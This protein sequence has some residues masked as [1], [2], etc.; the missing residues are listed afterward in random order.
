MERLTE[1]IAKINGKREYAAVNFQRAPGGNKKDF[2]N[3]LGPYEDLGTVEELTAN[4]E[5]FAA[6]RHVCGGRPPE[7]IAVLVKAQKEGLLVVLEGITTG[8]ANTIMG[9][10]EQLNAM[11]ARHGDDQE[12]LITWQLYNALTKSFAR[13]E[14]EEALSGGDTK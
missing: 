6:Y 8:Q 10:C 3:A 4:M 1:F 9:M 11:K 12:P 2:I 13:A 5:M 7:E 14:A